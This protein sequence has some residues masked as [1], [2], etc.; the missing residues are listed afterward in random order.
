MPTNS[1]FATDVSRMRQQPLYVIQGHEELLPEDLAVTARIADG[2]RI[3][4]VGSPLL[5]AMV[6]GGIVFFDDFAGSQVS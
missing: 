1:T 3:E 6:M 5:A 2:Q 4:Y